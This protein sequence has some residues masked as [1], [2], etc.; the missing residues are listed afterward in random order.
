MVFLLVRQR[1]PQNPSLGIWGQ[2]HEES[3]VHSAVQLVCDDAANQI[4]YQKF[5][6]N[7]RRLNSNEQLKLLT[8]SMA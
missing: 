5:T 8:S 7:S 2:M 4:F 6:S 1:P 3:L